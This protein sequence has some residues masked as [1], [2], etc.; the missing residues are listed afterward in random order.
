MDQSFVIIPRSSIHSF[1]HSFI[2]TYVVLCVTLSCGILGLTGVQLEHS[3][4]YW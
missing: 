2:M 4:H 1:V 3:G